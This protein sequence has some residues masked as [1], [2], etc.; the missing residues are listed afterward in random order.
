MIQGVPAVP[1]SYALRRDDWLFSQKRL[2]DS[3]SSSGGMT[4]V[5]QEIY[6]ALEHSG[7][8]GTALECMRCGLR[9]NRAYTR[10][11]YRDAN[12]IFNTGSDVNRD[13]HADNDAD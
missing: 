12:T 13:V 3:G 5:Y 4:N 9:E 6:N 1:R 11:A 10:V 8:T 7:F 2:W